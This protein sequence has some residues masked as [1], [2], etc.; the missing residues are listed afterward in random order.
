MDYLWF[1]GILGIF[2]TAFFLSLSFFLWLLGQ[3][4]IEVWTSD[5]ETDKTDKITLE[6]IW[7]FSS[8]KKYQ[9]I[10]KRICYDNFI[11]RHMQDATKI[12]KLEEEE[13]KIWQKICRWLDIPAEIAKVSIFNCVSMT[14]PFQNHL[15][16]LSL[17]LL[18]FM[19]Q[20]CCPFSFCFSL[21]LSFSL[22]LVVC[23]VFFLNKKI[24]VFQWR[25]RMDIFWILYSIKSLDFFSFSPNI[26]KVH[27]FDKIAKCNEKEIVLGQEEVIVV[28]NRI[29]FATRTQH[30]ESA[31]ERAFEIAS[32]QIIL[33]FFVICDL[34]ERISN[35]KRVF[36]SMS[37]VHF[38][39]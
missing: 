35:K 6:T 25:N 1:G 36:C 21:T 13:P 10:R 20:F 38:M 11:S 22:F 4:E 23:S 17:N 8:G 19:W 16:S 30:R 9:N 12:T 31:H 15:S 39:R 32:I 34:N 7:F 28:C 3:N 2:L 37:E 29:L 33:I 27:F 18:S 14:L 26:Y 5:G 24:I